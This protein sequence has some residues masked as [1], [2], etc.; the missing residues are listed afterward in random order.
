[1]TIDRGTREGLR[2]RGSNVALI[3]H[4]AGLGRGTTRQAGRSQR[5][6]S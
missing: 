3:L 6:R 5:R 4:H 2:A 1:M